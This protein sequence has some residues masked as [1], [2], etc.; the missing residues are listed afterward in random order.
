MN[1]SETCKNAGIKNLK[2][3]CDLVEQS[4]QTL[5]NWFHYKRKLFHCVLIGAVQIKK[6]SNKR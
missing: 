2:Y 5:N 4:P 1:A 3:L 6:E